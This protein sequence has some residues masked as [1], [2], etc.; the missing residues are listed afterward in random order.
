M[1]LPNAALCLFGL[2]FLFHHQ[3]L[4]VRPVL[5]I[6]ISVPF[7][8]SDTVPNIILVGI[9]HSWNSFCRCLE[10]S[11]AGKWV[12]HESGHDREKQKRCWIGYLKAVIRMLMLQ[13]AVCRATSAQPPCLHALRFSSHPTPSPSSC[14]LWILAAAL[15][16]LQHTLPH[17]TCANMISLVELNSTTSKLE[18]N[19]G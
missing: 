2:V 15:L 13:S 4:Y 3:Y 12:N 17:L 14:F 19:A 18:E 1:S 6:S 16:S 9:F 10:V 7:S 8:G 11:S 5:K